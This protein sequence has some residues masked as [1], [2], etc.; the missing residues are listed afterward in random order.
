MSPRLKQNFWLFFGVLI[1]I[2]LIFYAVAGLS[3]AQQCDTTSLPVVVNLDNEK[4]IDTIAHAS[5]AVLSGQPRILH[6]DRVDAE[7]HRRASL[8]KFPTRRGFDRDEYPPAA[9]T[10][11]GAGAD[12][13]YVISADNRSAGARMSIQLRPYCEGQAFILEPGIP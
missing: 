5:G 1:A 6:I 9:S 13:S 4:N 3:Q 11:G 2:I 12:I 7:A 10:E 8:R